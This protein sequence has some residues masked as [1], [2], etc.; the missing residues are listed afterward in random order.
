M[1][2]DCGE[3]GRLELSRISPT[4]VV[5]RRPKNIP[6]CHADLVVVV[7]GREMRSKVEV[8]NGFHPKRRAALVLPVDLV[9]PF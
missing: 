9:A 5:A 3:H 6:P 4:H 7:D 8:P 2:L 1:W